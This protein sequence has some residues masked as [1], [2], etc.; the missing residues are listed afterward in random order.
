MPSF[1]RFLRFIFVICLLG[2]GVL[3]ALDL[4]VEP[5]PSTI[6]QRVPSTAFTQAVE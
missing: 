1:F 3:L 5:E 6:S 4:L 2:F